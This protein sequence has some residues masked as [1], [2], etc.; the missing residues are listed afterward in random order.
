MEESSF[1]VK[2]LGIDGE[3]NFFWAGAVTICNIPRSLFFAQFNKSG[4]K[5]TE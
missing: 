3:L 4:N 1:L 2:T 5:N